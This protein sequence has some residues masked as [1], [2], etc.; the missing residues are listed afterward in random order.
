M[1]ALG[2]DICRRTEQA[3]R[4]RS[5]IVADAS[6]GR[7]STARRN[8]QAVSCMVGQVQEFVL[9]NLAPSPSA[10]VQASTSSARER[11]DAEIRKAGKRVDGGCG[12][13]Y[14]RTRFKGTNLP[15]R[16]GDHGPQQLIIIAGRGAG[17]ENESWIN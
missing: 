11:A 2:R 13:K 12:R 5:E 10:N 17:S 15:D 14:G 9:L 7:P 4:G 6:A 1:P 8:I 16:R 3:P